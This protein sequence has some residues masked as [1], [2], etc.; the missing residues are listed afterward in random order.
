MITSLRQNQIASLFK[1]VFYKLDNN[2]K[3]R[4]FGVSWPYGSQLNSICFKKGAVWKRLG[5]NPKEDEAWS[6]PFSLAVIWTPWTPRFRG[7]TRKTNKVTWYLI[8]SWLSVFHSIYILTVY[9][10]FRINLT[11]YLLALMIYLVTIV[12][13]KKK[14]HEWFF[15]RH[16]HE[17]TKFYKILTIL[18][19]KQN[20]FAL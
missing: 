20:D 17:F 16:K 11:M 10:Q 4:M 7:D 12:S 19:L 6:E 14:R 13:A 15:F 5:A 1:I 3:T 18:H 9:L 8:Y 2:H